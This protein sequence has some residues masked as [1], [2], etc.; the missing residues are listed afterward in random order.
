[1]HASVA[2]TLEKDPRLAQSDPGFLALQFDKAGLAENAIEWYMKAGH[3]AT[4][5]SANREALHYFERALALI[6]EAMPG[7][8]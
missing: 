6:N 5:R 3:Q 8:G 1:L 7:E 4:V 2:T